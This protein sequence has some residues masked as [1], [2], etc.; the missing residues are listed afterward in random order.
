MKEEA[1]ASLMRYVLGKKGSVKKTDPYALFSAWARLYP[2]QTE[3][4]DLPEALAIISNINDIRYPA[5]FAAQ[6]LNYIPGR[7]QKNDQD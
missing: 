4:K 1:A 3:D 5:T 2:E 7:N 6:C